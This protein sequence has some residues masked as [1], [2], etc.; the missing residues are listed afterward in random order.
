MNGKRHDRELRKLR[1]FF[2]F[3]GKESKVADY[4]DSS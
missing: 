2:Q 1:C 4:E 3:P